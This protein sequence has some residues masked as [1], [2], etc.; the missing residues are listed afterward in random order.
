MPF[1]KTP[2]VQKTEAKRGEA[3]V[4]LPTEFD[5]RPLK[6][7]SMSG[8]KESPPMDLPVDEESAPFNLPTE[9]PIKPQE[10]PIITDVSGDI[11]TDND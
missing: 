8:I 3:P 1:V 6:S 11:K 10:T 5:Q 9:N 7:K 2:L 4:D